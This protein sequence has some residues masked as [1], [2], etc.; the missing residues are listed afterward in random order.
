MICLADGTGKP[1]E[2]GLNYYNS[3][4]DVLLDKGF[5]FSTFQCLLD[6]NFCLLPSFYDCI[7][8]VFLRLCVRYTTICN[9]LPLGSSASTGRQIRWLVK[10]TNCVWK[11]LKRSMYHFNYLIQENSSF[12]W[13]SQL[14][15]AGRIL[16]TM[17]PLASRNLEIEWSIG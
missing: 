12:H 11:T 14:I 1:N 13:S 10:L 9:T 6:A 7:S 17:P 15:Y 16:F 2:E 3:L 8:L 4:I 5:P